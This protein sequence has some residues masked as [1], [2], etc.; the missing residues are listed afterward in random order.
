MGLVSGGRVLRAIILIFCAAISTIGCAT[1]AVAQQKAPAPTD[2]FGPP[3][4]PKVVGGDRTSIEYWPSLVS[5]RYNNPASPGVSGHVCGGSIIAPNWVLTAA[6]CAVL[7]EHGGTL[8]GVFPDDAGKARQGKLDVVI[9]IDDLEKV[10][11]DNVYPVER[12]IV[13]PKFLAAFRQRLGVSDKNFGPVDWA[14]V[15]AGH[16]IALVQLKRRWEGALATLSLALETD[17]PPQSGDVILAGFGYWDRDANK[18]AM[19]R[20]PRSNGETAFAGFRFLQAGKVPMVD[21]DRCRQKYKSN[22]FYTNSVIGEEQICAGMEV[23]AAKT[24]DSCQGDSGGPLMAYDAVDAK[25]QVGVVSWGAGCAEAGWYGIYTRVSAYADWIQ[26][27]TGPIANKATPRPVE[28]ASADLQR[29][30]MQFTRAAVGQLSETLG[31]AQH[32]VRLNLTGGP[33]LKLNN[34]YSIEVETDIAGRLV[35]VDVDAAGVVTQ[36]FPN[37]YTPDS[38]TWSVKAKQKLL[39]PPADRSWPR[40]DGF[41]ATEPIGRGRLIALIVPETF[42]I[43]ATIASATQLS[44]GLKPVEAPT[45]YVMN[46]V[47]QVTQNVNRA[48]TGQGA[49]ALAGWGLGVLEYEIVR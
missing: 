28:V 38:K 34:K 30:Q 44:K 39:I 21:T 16:D 15:N 45:N 33:R 1:G 11:Q 23:G 48:G 22:P 40:L 6:H 12:V 31:P 27:H 20:I 5:L 2:R 47:D 19:R 13:H 3:G 17:P 9:G 36:I 24:I 4:R 25:F 7:L 10:G 26:G 35:L 43:T 18:R 8:D 42:P 41:Q 29:T 32:R 37:E 14:S 49:S 46:L